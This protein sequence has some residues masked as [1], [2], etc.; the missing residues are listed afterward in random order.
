MVPKVKNLYMIDRRRDQLGKESS[1]I[2][3]FSSSSSFSSFFDQLEI[4]LGP[5]VINVIIDR[6]LISDFPHTLRIY[7]LKVSFE[8]KWRVCV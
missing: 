7:R 4:R 3:F 6:S 2:V 8:R 5:E 1:S